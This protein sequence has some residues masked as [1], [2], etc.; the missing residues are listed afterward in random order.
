MAI[1]KPQGLQSRDN[2]V[3]LELEYESLAQQFKFFLSRVDSNGK[4]QFI[5]FHFSFYF[6]CFVQYFLFFSRVSALCICDF[7]TLGQIS[8]QIERTSYTI[9]V[10]A[11]PRITALPPGAGG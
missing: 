6:P 11:S 4:Y 8:L 5:F 9:N 10:R 1:A 3:H 2:F 7:M